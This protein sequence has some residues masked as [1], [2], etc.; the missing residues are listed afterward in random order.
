MNEKPEFEVLRNSNAIQ[1]GDEFLAFVAA[2]D[3]EDPQQ[4]KP[5]QS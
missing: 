1:V 4:Q 2:M 3:S 5:M